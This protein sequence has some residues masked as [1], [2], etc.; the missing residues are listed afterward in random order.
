VAYDRA[1]GGV[2]GRF[3]RWLQ[4][5]GREPGFSHPAPIALGALGTPERAGCFLNGLAV[6][7]GRAELA[8]AIRVA[9]GG[10]R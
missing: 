5:W 9:R 6:A 7:A 10:E 1:A 2:R 8:S 3:Q 4:T